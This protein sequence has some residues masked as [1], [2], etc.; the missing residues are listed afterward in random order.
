MTAQERV[1]AL[2]NEYNAAIRDVNESKGT[3]LDKEKLSNDARRLSLELL[4]AEDDLQKANTEAATKAAEQAMEKAKA[5]EKVTAALIRQAEEAEKILA[6]NK[7]IADTLEKL[8]QKAFEQTTYGLVNS[9][10]SSDQIRSAS[11][12]ALSEA[13]RRLNDELIT[14][15][16]DPGSAFNYGNSLGI[17]KDENTIAALQNELR[18]RQQV[19]TGSLSSTSLDPLV[20]DRL[21][22][23]LSGALATTA[24]TNRLLKS[25][26]PVIVRNP[27]T[28]LGTG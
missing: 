15:R 12:E 7:E 24:E 27:P 3:I 21:S 1:N 22:K 18:L 23:E 16:Q 2:Q 9:K 20:F 14:L 13:I 8:N 28:P 6:K 25:G 5:E 10:Y 4:K 17:T 26:I 19:T 11:P